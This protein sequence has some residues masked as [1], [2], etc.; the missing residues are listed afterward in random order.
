[1]DSRAKL[2]SNDFSISDCFVLDSNPIESYTYKI[3]PN[4]TCLML[5]LNYLNKL[6]EHGL[7]LN[8]VLTTS[9]FHVNLVI[10]S[11]QFLYSD[12][13]KKTG[14]VRVIFVCINTFDY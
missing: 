7:L 5:Y 8:I 3:K 9:I 14:R 2:G 6:V 11:T 12:L 4:C 13:K 1:M 10:A